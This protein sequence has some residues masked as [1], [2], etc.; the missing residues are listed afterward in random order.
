M[1]GNIMAKAETTAVAVKE[2]TNLALASQYSEDSGS[3]FEE[4]SAESF[5]IP[6]LSI[7]QSGSPQ[8]KK[9]DGAYNYVI[10]MNFY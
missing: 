3:G 2:E 4:T 8:C 10:N 6:F 9:S 5:A 7:L 1:K